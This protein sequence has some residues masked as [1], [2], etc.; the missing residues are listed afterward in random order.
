MVELYPK[1][2]PTC[3]GNQA[4]TVTLH[5]GRRKLDRQVL[6]KRSNESLG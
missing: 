2:S 1:L 3:T 4:I 6:T 5:E